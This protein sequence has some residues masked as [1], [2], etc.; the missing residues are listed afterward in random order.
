MPT[1]LHTHGIAKEI[2]KSYMNRADLPPVFVISLRG[3]RLRDLADDLKA[4]CERNHGPR[5]VC[6]DCP[7]STNYRLN[8][9][10]F[11]IFSI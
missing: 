11:Y 6:C 7:L 5:G 9:Q 1:A 10:I 4:L 8:V 2:N 3:T